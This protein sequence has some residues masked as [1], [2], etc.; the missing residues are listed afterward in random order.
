MEKSARGGFDLLMLA[1]QLGESFRGTVFCR[2]DELQVVV[3]G[4]GGGGGVTD[5]WGMRE[6][7]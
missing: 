5:W 1:L 2:T 6:G 7:T 3:W 4:G